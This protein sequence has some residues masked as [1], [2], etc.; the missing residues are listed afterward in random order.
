MRSANITGSILIGLLILLPGI[1][2][3][4][5]A[6]ATDATT[7]GELRTYSTIHSIG[8]EWDII[9]DAN[10]NAVCKVQYQT[11]GGANAWKDAFALVRVHCFNAWGERKANR[12]Y[13]MVAGSIFFL[14]PDTAYQV[15]LDLADPDGGADTQTVAIR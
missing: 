2:S 9:G 14:E 12:P 5:E 1:V 7:P 11:T 4:H 15:R 8:V 13:N 3:T 10:H 6:N